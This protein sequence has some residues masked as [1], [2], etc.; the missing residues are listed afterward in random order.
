MVCG[1][2]VC[3]KST[4]VILVPN[5][6]DLVYNDNVYSDSEIFFHNRKSTLN[7]NLSVVCSDIEVSLQEVKLVLKLKFS[8]WD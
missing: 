6:A 1:I 8:L 7:C 4:A 3:F 2:R 5:R